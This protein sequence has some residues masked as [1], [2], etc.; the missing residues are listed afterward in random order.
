MIVLYIQFLP[1]TKDIPKIRAFL[2]Q[3]KQAARENPFWFDGFNK[4]NS[5]LKQK[6]T[7]FGEQ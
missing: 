7:S 1:G 6:V 5:N 3:F 2:N 4:I